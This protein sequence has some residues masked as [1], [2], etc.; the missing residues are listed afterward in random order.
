MQVNKKTLD[1]L[2]KISTFEFQRKKQIPYR[3]FE[4]LEQLMIGAFVIT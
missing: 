1:F 3:L 4:F 2:E